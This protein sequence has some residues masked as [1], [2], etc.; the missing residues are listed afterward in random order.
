MRTHE[1][2]V[3]LKR[4]ADMPALGWISGD[5]HMHG[6]YRAVRQWTTPADDLLVVQAEDL[7][8]ANMMV[9][10]SDGDFL[11]DERYFSGKG[12]DAVSTRGV[13]AVLERGDAES[14]DV[15]PSPL[16]RFAG[17]GPAGLFRISRN[18]ECRRL[19]LESGL[20]EQ[21]QTAGRDRDVCASRV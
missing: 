18:T 20:G 17:V 21:C 19:A 2:V 15:R 5:D 1:D 16:F 3:R 9:S 14:V 11:H 10:N 12:P 6:N 13:Q 4:L 8:V 7:H